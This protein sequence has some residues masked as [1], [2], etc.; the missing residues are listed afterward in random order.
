VQSQESDREGGAGVGRMKDGIQED[1]YSA[2][3]RCLGKKPPKWEEEDPTKLVEGGKAY[4][5][6]QA[7]I[8]AADELDKLNEYNCICQFNKYGIGVPCRKCLYGDIIKKL[9]ISAG[10]K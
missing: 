7:L 2:S 9:R 10:V 8:E 5:Y 1:G 6:R 4:H 3:I